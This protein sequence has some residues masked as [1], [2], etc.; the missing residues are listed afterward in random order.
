M[1]K[2]KFDTDVMSHPEAAAVIAMLQN[3]FGIQAVVAPGVEVQYRGECS[4]DNCDIGHTHVHKEM[5]SSTAVEVVEKATTAAQDFAAGNAGNTA[6]KPA[7]A[8]ATS[9]DERD[10]EGIIWDER[11]HAA[12]KAKSESGKWTRK[13][14]IDDALYKAVIAEQKAANTARTM[15][16]AAAMQ[17]TAPTEPPAT[18]AAEDFAPAQTTTAPA[19]Q[20]PAT[21]AAPATPPPAQTAAPATGGPAPAFAA[22]IAMLSQATSA[23]LFPNGY[24]YIFDACGLKGTPDLIQA[25]DAVRQAVVDMIPVA[26]Q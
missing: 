18:T 5:L 4:G 13:R 21:T 23:G 16:A 24:Q 26:P 22:I 1:V 12:N 3:L 25:P 10:S 2:V 17:T 8:P 9:G 6:E 11:I 20:P 14:K 15:E 19:T 7:S